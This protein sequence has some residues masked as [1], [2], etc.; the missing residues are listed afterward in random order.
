MKTGTRRVWLCLL[1]L[2]ERLCRRPKQPLPNWLARAL[3]CSS[4]IKL[5]R[6][7]NLRRRKSE[8]RKLRKRR[9]VA[10]HRLNRVNVSRYRLTR[11]FASPSSSW[12]PQSARALLLVSTRNLSDTAMQNRNPPSTENSAA[13]A[14]NQPLKDADFMDDDGIDDAGDTP[15]VESESDLHLG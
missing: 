7:K 13:R 6:G 14:A 8:Q 4:A 11:E 5:R 9:N 10:P 15:G 3:A 12:N 2:G 1:T